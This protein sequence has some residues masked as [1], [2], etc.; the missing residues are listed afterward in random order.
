MRVYAILSHRCGCGVVFQRV[1]VCHISY[2]EIKREKNRKIF[3]WNNY[4][5]KEMTFLITG[6]LH[7]C[8]VVLPAFQNSIINRSPHDIREPKFETHYWR[9]SAN[10]DGK[11][12]LIEDTN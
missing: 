6:G 9:A 4:K 12:K 10:R 5:V 1:P 2:K 11:E 3:D 7:S 8:D